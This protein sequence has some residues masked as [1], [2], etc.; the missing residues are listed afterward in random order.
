MNALVD[1]PSHPR[2]LATDSPLLSA[3]D[4]AICV[5]HRY[6]GTEMRPRQ[7]DD[8]YQ[9]FQYIK[10]FMNTKPLVCA[11]KQTLARSHASFA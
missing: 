8:Y 3:E 5:W 6:T 9:E 10:A 4:V 11:I 2:L 7:I 1:L